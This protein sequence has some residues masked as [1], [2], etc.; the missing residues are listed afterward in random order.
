VICDRCDQDAILRQRYS[1]LSL[2][3][4][5]FLSA[6]EARAKQ[7]IRAHGWI[8]TGDRIAV[9]LSGGPASASLLHFLASRFGMRRDL[10]LIAI[11]VDG[12]AG[13]GREMDRIRRMAEKTGVRWVGASPSANSGELPDGI[14]VSSERGAIRDNRLR[15]LALA[16]LAEGAGA[17]KLA[18]GT[19]LD[20]RAG[21]VF[22]KVLRGDG[23][24]LIHD[25]GQRRAGIQRI[26]P[27]IRIPA[28]ELS[29]Y[30]RLNSLDHI[31]AGERDA[32]GSLE[33]EA[34]RILSQYTRRH[35]SSMFALANLG[36]NLS[37]PDPGARGR[38]H[39]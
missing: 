36:D 1:G 13:Q 35:P 16:A 17:T 8:R 21:S 38:G 23:S 11:T 9:A 33:T 27:F 7:T 31:L 32:P 3:R 20:R 4:E 6:L 19:S 39:G 34:C 2:C 37:A 28:E 26:E 5:H 15:D 14:A 30:A 24:G 18:L 29:L 12:G 22:L 25:P 10:S